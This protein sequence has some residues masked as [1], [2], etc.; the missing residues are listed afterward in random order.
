MIVEQIENSDY[1]KASLPWWSRVQ[2]FLRTTDFS[3]LSV[4]RQEID[5]DYMYAIVADDSSRNDDV[6]L[7]A[8]RQYI[9]VQVAATGS[10]DILWKPLSTCV[11]E[12]QAYDIDKDYCLM[13]DNALSRITVEPGTAVILFPD[14]AHAP[15][16]PLKHVRKVVVKVAVSL[17]P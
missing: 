2:S 3:L 5:G 8:H 9:D 15:Q 4:G 7:E 14:D 13:N 1:L 12:R 10:F 17:M 6:Y 16:P 11:S